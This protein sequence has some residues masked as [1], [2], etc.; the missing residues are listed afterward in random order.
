[1]NTALDTITPADPLDPELRALDV[2]VGVLDDVARDRKAALLASL[3]S[4][5]T[6]APDATDAPLDLADRRDHGRRRRPRAW[7]LLPAAAAATAVGLLVLPGGVAPKAYA[8]WTATPSPLS[9]A[10]LTL[11]TDACRAQLARN[12]E[13]IEGVPPE[14]QPNVK[15]ETARTVVAERRGAYVFVA[16]RTDTDSTASC[17][18]TA[19]SPGQ[20]GSASGGVVTAAS[21]VPAPLEPTQLGASGMGITSGP[22][23][24]IIS[25]IGRVGAD[26]RAVTIHSE[27][28]TIRATVSESYVAAWWPTTSKDTAEPVLPPITTFDVTLADGRVLTNVDSGIPGL[29]PP[30][31]RQ[32]NSVVVGGGAVG[33]QAVATLVGRAGSEVKSVRIQAGDTVIDA[34]VAAGVFRATWDVASVESVSSPDAIRYTLTL[35]DGTV[36]TNVTPVGR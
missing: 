19:D 14:Q 5:P 15:P 34:P 2:A 20:V 16:L 31:R 25:L 33:V 22:E 9:G 8:T 7:W 17:L 24:A 28:A 23:G 11:A 1:M 36:L 6:D 18:S 21:S 13:P 4:I 27:G 35:T 12:A 26:V 29:T 3:V 10:D 32:I 30:G